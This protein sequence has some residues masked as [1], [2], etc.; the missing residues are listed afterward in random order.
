METQWTELKAVDFAE[1]G[2][3]AP[4]DRLLGDAIEGEWTLFAR[5]DEVEAAW[6]VV[7]PVLK[8]NTP[9]EI[10]E[11]GSWGPKSAALLAEMYGGWHDPKVGKGPEL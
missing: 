7:D 4:Y 6:E 9:L 11:P 3:L 5:Q 10:Y 8:A 2:R 1:K